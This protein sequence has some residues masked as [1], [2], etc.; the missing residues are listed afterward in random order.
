VLAPATKGRNAQP[1]GPDAMSRSLALRQSMTKA[2]YRG[3]FGRTRKEL[4]RLLV[5]RG[6][7]DDLGK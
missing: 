6:T 7:S 5:P 2:V 1:C 4:E 3:K